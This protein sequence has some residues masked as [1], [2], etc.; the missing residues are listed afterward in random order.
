[1]LWPSDHRDQPQMSLIVRHHQN[2]SRSTHPNLI[3][4]FAQHCLR[5]RTGACC[6]AC[7]ADHIELLLS[8]N[9]GKAQG[10][11]GRMAAQADSQP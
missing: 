10:A 2:Q 7:S 1:M 3:A 8:T 5:A 11:G 9:A 4:L 6:N